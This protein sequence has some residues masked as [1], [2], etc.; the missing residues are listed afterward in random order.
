MSDLLIKALANRHLQKYIRKIVKIIFQKDEDVPM[1]KVKFML[2]AVS[3][4][5]ASAFAARPVDLSKE[6]LDFLNQLSLPTTL[7]AANNKDTENFRE[8]SRTQDL[9]KTTHV[10]IKE[11]FAGYTVWNGDGVIHIPKNKNNNLKN[12]LINTRANSDVSMNGILYEDLQEDL[13]STPSYVFEPAQAK[14]AYEAAVAEFKAKYPTSD[15]KDTKNELV[16][17][18]DDDNRAHWTF[19]I[20]FSAENE[21][22]L[23]QPNFLIDATSLKSFQQWDNVKTLDNVKGGG[24][25]GNLKRGKLSYDG[26]EGHLPALD[27]QRDASNA[28]CFLK[29]TTVEILDYKTRRPT[30][31]TCIAKDKK[32]NDVFWN[33]KPDEVNGGYSP[34]NDSLYAGKVLQ[35]M[36]KDFYNL[37]VLTKKNKPMKLTILTHARIENAEWRDGANVMVIGNG[38]DIF[39]PLVSVGVIAHEVSHGFTAQHSNLN[40]FGQSGGINEAFSDMAAQVA[41]FYADGKNS[42]QIGPEIIKEKNSALRYMDHPTKDCNGEKPGSNCSIENA[43]D[44]FVGINVHYS[45]GVYN[46]AFYLLATSDGWDVKKAFNAM[47]QANKNY[48]T[49]SS[50]YKQAACGVVKAA[51]DLKYETVAIKRAFT[52]VGIATRNC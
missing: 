44:Y 13:A 19:H 42:W 35:A 20:S 15:I 40:Y 51:A 18:V 37:D 12:L 25:G 4:V 48:W 14:K 33:N 5:S 39:Y 50:N 17:Y 45:S 24:V 2:F 36:Y 10:R 52:K 23:Y 49:P 1:G 27:V 31:Y 22:H 16:V 34:N 7:S 9:N 3:F 21:D 8:V 46:R 26:L 32:H 43:R 30:F 47:L 41:E 38:K 6:K 28:A 11:T 29:N